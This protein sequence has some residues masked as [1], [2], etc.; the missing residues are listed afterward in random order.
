MLISGFAAPAAASALSEGGSGR[1]RIHGFLT[2]TVIYISD[3]NFY[4]DTDDAISFDYPEAGINGSWLIHPDPL[5]SGQLL[6]RK[7][8]SR[9]ADDDG[10]V[11]CLLPRGRQAVRSPMAVPPGVPLRRD[12]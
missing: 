8:G 6:Y 7:A 3:N 5:V 10:R 12:A 11:P 4:G 9:E 2:Q 1:L